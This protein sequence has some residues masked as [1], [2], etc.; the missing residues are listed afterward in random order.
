[1]ITLSRRAH[2]SSGHRY[3]NPK[4]S[5]EK[6]K[7]IFGSSYSEHG[8]GHNYIL[9]AQIKGPVSPETGM[10]INLSD[11]DH[12]LNT[13]CDT[14]DHK[15]LNDSVDYFKHITPT[16]ENI[17]KY[18]FDKIN[19]Q[20]DDFPKISLHKVRVFEGDDLWADYYG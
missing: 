19:K 5:N 9:E 16:T 2:F 12:I 13:V 3:F 20:L 4:W 10:I 15:F 7:S 11:L 6:N 18:C 1:M 17:A 14:L 8:H